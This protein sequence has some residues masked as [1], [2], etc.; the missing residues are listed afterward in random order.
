MFPE[1]NERV[2]IHKFTVP[3]GPQDL[4]LYT[5]AFQFLLYSKHL[6]SVY[7]SHTHYF[8]SSLPVTNYSSDFATYWGRNFKHL[9]HSSTGLRGVF[10][11]GPCVFIVDDFNTREIQ[12]SL[13]AS[14]SLEKD[15]K[16]IILCFDNS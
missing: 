8:F 13:A 3:D 11:K 10:S 2:V 16:L 1:K 6:A 9:P 12:L 7:P 4:R 14:M 5:A 15:T